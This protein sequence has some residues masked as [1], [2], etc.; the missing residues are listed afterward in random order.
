MRRFFDLILEDSL[1]ITV[2]AISCR[3]V[4]KAMFRPAFFIR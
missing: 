2:K 3:M 4:T 1:V